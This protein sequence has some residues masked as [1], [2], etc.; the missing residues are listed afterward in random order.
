LIPFQFFI[1]APPIYALVRVG[2]NARLERSSKNW[3]QSEIGTTEHHLSHVVQTVSTQLF[4]PAAAIILARVR[5]DDDE[6]TPDY[7][8]AA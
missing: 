2:T 6:V 4:E 5:L 3:I 8:E 7:I 1:H